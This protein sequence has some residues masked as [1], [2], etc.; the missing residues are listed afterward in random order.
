M[1][2][3]DSCGG[4]KQQTKVFG[5]NCGARSVNPLKVFA[6]KLGVVEQQLHHL[7]LTH[8]LYLAE[9]QLHH[10]AGQYHTTSLGTSF[11]TS[12][13]LTTTLRTHG[14]PC[15]ALTDHSSGYF[16]LRL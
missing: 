8:H 10:L 14:S 7:Y 13:S 5:V 1:L 2:T 3:V 6:L 4:L 16:P 9:Q 12:T 11:T 15:C